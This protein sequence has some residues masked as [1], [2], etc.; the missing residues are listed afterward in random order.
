MA[1]S[2]A[3]RSIR[4]SISSQYLFSDT[5]TMADSSYGNRAKDCHI[6]DG[7]DDLQRLTYTI[8]EQTNTNRN[9][10]KVNW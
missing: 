5:W 3:P 4:L 1:A 8:Y 10:E 9:Q 7:K 6:I 2:R